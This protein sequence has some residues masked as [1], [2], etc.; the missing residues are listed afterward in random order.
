MTDPAPTSPPTAPAR[1]SVALCTF[2]GARFV[3]DQLRS[4]AAQT[5]P[6]DEIVVCD[7][8][9]TDGTLDAVHAAGFPVRVVRNARRLGV[10]KNFEQAIGLCTGDAILLCDQ[11]D[12]WHPD[13]VAVLLARL[14]AGPAMAFS[15]AE[16]VDAELAPAGYRLWDSV[17]FDAAEQARVRR[18]DAVPVLLRHAVAAG[19]TLAFGAAFKPLLLPIPD[20]PHSHDIWVTL[21]LACVGRLDPVDRDL[22]RYRLHGANAV[23]LRRHGLLS[24]VRMARHQLRNG[25]FAYLA[26]LCAAAH[27][28]L[29]VHADRWPVSPAVLDLLRAKVDHSRCRHDLPRPWLRR[30]GVVGREVRRGNYVKY[31]YGYK[32]VLQD[33]FLR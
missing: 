7:D 28:R 21:L 31:S 22:I 2:N 13:K 15:N 17:W 18:G 16:V 19:S 12:V 24:Q 3:A 1:A 29:T 5:R 33:L 6:V 30:L 4:I 8:G 14:S 9:S 10:T 11:D 23:G 32:S 20:L 25:T 26:E 27:D